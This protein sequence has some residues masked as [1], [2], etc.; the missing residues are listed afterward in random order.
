M[1]EL[2]YSELESQRFGKEIFR[3]NFD[4][5]NISTLQ[6]FYTMNDPDILIFRIPVSEQYKMHQ[7][8]ELNKDI[9]N[10]DTLVY[11]QVDVKKAVLNYTEKN[12]LT[13]INGSNS[14]EVFENMIK[15]I[16]YNYQN[17]Y[18]SN[19]LI[20]R[21]KIAEGYAEWAVNTINSGQNHNLLA[22]INN[23]PVGF[24]TCSY[25]NDYAD[26]ILNGVLP[27]YQNRGI[28]TEMIRHVKNYLYELKVPILKI[29]TQI[30]NI[31]VQKVWNREGFVLKSAYVTIHLNKKQ[32]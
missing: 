32:S 3:G 26:I 18:Y 30:Q 7:L 16:F 17:H 11:Y 20:N 10:A 12:D 29:S 31:G 23:I 2:K 24:L 14:S 1:D 19:P 28:Y 25:N 4:V 13:I 9:I 22:F 27:E 6:D 15:K 5:L 8:S 21:E